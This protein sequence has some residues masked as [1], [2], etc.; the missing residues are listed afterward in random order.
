MMEQIVFNESENRNT[1]LYLERI[2]LQK[3]MS[4][5]NT[6]PFLES[7]TLSVSPSTNFSIS[8]SPIVEDIEEVDLVIL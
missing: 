4:E 6:F 1:T 8:A 2:V 7:N 3:T 5:T